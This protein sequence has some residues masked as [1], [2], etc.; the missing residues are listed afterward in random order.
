ML[1]QLSEVS[2]PVSVSCRLLCEWSQV[3]IARDWA[4]ARDALLLHVELMVL[5]CMSSTQGSRRYSQGISNG[6]RF[7]FTDEN[8]NTEIPTSLFKNLYLA[9]SEKK[10][11]SGCVCS[12]FFF[13]PPDFGGMI[14]HAVLWKF[15][16]AN[17]DVGK[18]Y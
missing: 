2:G 16:P 13:V 17:R 10:T 12:T 5:W 3:C 8:K 6:L 7:S 15:F 11:I 14:T 9:D 4:S 1:L 18:K